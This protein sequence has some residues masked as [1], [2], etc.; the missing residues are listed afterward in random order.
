MG[1]V[2]E[3][4]KP[5]P[6]TDHE[7]PE[8]ERYVYFCSFFNL[9]A[10]W[11]GWST[12]CPGRNLPPGKTQYQLC[13]RLDGLQGRSGRMRKISSP[14]GFDPQTFQSV[15]LYLLSYPGPPNGRSMARN[16]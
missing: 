10:R 7:D 11:G 15:V 4:D 16:P 8:G 13:R 5:H 3:K 6:I 14:K 2:N 9:G 12:P 1:A